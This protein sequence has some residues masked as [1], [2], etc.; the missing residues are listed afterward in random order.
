MLDVTG[1]THLW[2][3]EKQYLTAMIKRLKDGGYHIRAAIADTIG[4]AWAIAHYGQDEGIIETG[5][6]AAALLSLPPS[7][8]R[9][10]AETIERLEKLGLRQIR[11]FISMPPNA[12]RRRFGQHFLK[13]LN[14]LWGMKKR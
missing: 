13:R 10:E 14:R 11:N 7:A 8:L 2:G 1:C 4:S 6:Q 5:R 12:L 9:L 3:G